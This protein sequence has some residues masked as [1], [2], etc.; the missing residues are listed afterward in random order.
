MR[1][2]LRFSTLLYSGVL[3]LAG[4]IF[5]ALLLSASTGPAVRVSP[6]DSVG[7]RPLETQ[8]QS[9]V[10]R[11]YLLAWQT[12]G[13]AMAENRPDLLDAYFVG[14]AKEK[15]TDTIR[16]QQK[17]GIYASYLDKSH[18]IKVLFYSPEGLSIQLLDEVEYDV[19]VR[20]GD[21]GLGAQHVRA[22]Y[23][24]VLTPTES[25]WKVRVFQS[26]TPAR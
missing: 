16:E 26:G 3:C 15:L 13:T 20:N 5:A 24:A 4:A 9:S 22:R 23:V 8:T 7:P 11:D 19:D 10:I 25:K 18:D 14:Q 6:M 17:I 12:M 2:R 1:S 21:H